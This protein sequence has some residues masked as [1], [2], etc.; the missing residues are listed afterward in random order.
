MNFGFGN[1]IKNN[2]SSD[3]RFEDV[4]SNFFYVFC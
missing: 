1:K 3:L 2:S 4:F